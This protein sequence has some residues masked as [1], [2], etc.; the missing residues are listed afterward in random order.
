M[1]KFLDFDVLYGRLGSFPGDVNFR[2]AEALF[3][4]AMKAG[5]GAQFVELEPNTCRATVIIG[6]AARNLGGK[7]HVGGASF[8][9]YQIFFNRVVRLYRLKETV[10]ELASQ[11]GALDSMKIDF[12]LIRPPGLSEVLKSKVVFGLGPVDQIEVPNSLVEL[13]KGPDYVVWKGA[14]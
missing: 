13:E 4:W 1:D 2:Q 6:T 7:V 8:S 3:R 14:E 5:E 12:A 9:Q 10:F 11:N